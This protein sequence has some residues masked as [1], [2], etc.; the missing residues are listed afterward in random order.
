MKV[1][2]FGG[3]GM[4]GSVFSKY[5]AESGFDVTFTTRGTLPKFFPSAE[6][7]SV[8]KFDANKDILPN[9]NGYDVVINCIGAIKQ[10]EFAE[11]DFYFLN[12]V[13]P[14]MVS[15][16]CLEV[17]IPF[18]H[19]S[20]DC[21][22]AGNKPKYF[23]TEVR[24]ASDTYGISKALGEPTNGIVIRTSIIGP[25]DS[26]HG[27]FEW[28]RTN[29]NAKVPGYTNHKWSGVT[30]LFAAQFIGN[31]LLKSMGM[32]N[33]FKNKKGII[34]LASPEI[35]KFTLL[36]NINNVFQLG[37]TIVKTKDATDVSRVLLPSMA[38]APE[39]HD[40]LVEMKNWMKDSGLE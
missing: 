17:G 16:A 37:K 39:I 1:L 36:E 18:I 27:L 24:D 29:K 15:N 21:V 33:E 26:K 31:V 3:S 5:L 38:M 12:S 25:S 30:T 22:F 40:Q 9:M 10:K 32:D 34:Q 2:V 8:L 11:K 4:A 7:I 23:G 20:S 13:F 35:S 6:K 28:L 19:L 14:W